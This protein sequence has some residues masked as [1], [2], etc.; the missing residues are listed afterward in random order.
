M[1]QQYLEPQSRLRQI[2]AD[3]LPVPLFDQLHPEWQKELERHKNLIERID[4]FVQGRELAP[5]YDSIFR[6]LTQSVDS[7]RVVVFGQDPYPTKGHAHGLAFSVEASVSPLPPS[8]RN[9]YK[10]LQSDLG[11]VRTNGDLSDWAEQGV[12][13]INRVLSTDVGQSMAHS[14]LG[15]QE[16][17]ETVAQTLGK[18]DVIAVLWGNTA[19][20]LKHHFRPDDVV[21]SVHPSPL[22][23]HRGF[24]GSSPFSKVNAKLVAKGYK[25]ISW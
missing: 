13:L 24:F 2:Q 15:W 21:S 23:A 7:I 8:L 14:K 4:T 20:E 1:F 25:E 5:S 11:I 16:V 10:E 3:S 12:M 9:I 19:L 18:R 6:A 17:T 22:S